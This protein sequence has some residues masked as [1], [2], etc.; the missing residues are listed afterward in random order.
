MAKVVASDGV[1]LYA[2][3][4]GEGPPVVLSGALCTTRENYRAQVEPFVE[5]GVQ[6]ILWDYRGHGLSESPDDPAAYSLDQVVDDLGRILDWAAEG[7]AAVLGGLSFGGLA[8]LHY[9]HR[10]PERVRGLLLIDSGPGFKNP[11]A[12]ARWERSVEKTA[13]YVESKGPQAFVA[14]RAAP[15]LIGLRPE[16]PAARVAGEAIAAQNPV[17]L[18]HFA[19]QVAA[20]APPIIDELVEIDVPALVIVG[21]KDEAFLRAAEVMTARLPQAERCTLAGAGH[22]VNIEAADEFNAAATGF[23]RKIAGLESD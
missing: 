6:L 19:R 8:S 22:I 3:T 1:A 7:R 20:P 10:H 5:A 2:E 16:L 15:T 12:Q 17:G 21:E 9:T 14:S 13:S 18:A 11:D 4:H 23:L